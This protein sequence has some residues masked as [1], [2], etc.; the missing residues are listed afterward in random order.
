MI[1]SCL[2]TLEAGDVDELFEMIPRIGVLRDPRF[3]GHLLALLEDPD[4]KK[5]EFAAYAMGAMGKREF[6]GPLKKAFGQAERLGGPGVTDLEVAILEAI[7]TIGDDDAV[8]FFPPLLEPDERKGSRMELRKWV[9]ESLGA[10]AQQGGERSLQTLL[11]LTDHDDPDLRAQSLS[12]LAV[13]YWHRPN[14]IPEA[15]LERIDALRNDPD[16]EVAESALSA[17]ES[18][19]D[20]GCRKA[21]RL[22]ASEIQR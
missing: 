20:I 22:I 5:R 21:E 1:R 14:E 2:E 11:D 4:P 7:G 8:E 13:A 6:V 16:P 18:L 12:E 19:A 9:V 3:T 15:T 17:L 10:I